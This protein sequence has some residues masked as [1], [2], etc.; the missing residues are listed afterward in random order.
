MINYVVPFLVV[1]AILGTYAAQRP[2]HVHAVSD[3]G[4]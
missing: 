1:L 2:I 3:Y 4:L